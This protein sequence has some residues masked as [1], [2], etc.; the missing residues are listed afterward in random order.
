MSVAGSRPD[1]LSGIELLRFGAAFTVLI[2]HYF[3]FYMRGY[4]YEDYAFDRQPLFGV[5]EPL[6]RYGTRS[7]E[8]FWCLSG[9]I[10]FYQYGRILPTKAMSATRFFWLRFSRLYPL[11]FLT[12]LIV[13]LLQWVYH[14][15]HGVFFIVE[16]NNLKHFILNLLFVQY[17]GFQDG[18]SFNTPSWSVSVELL[19]YLFFYI[20]T[21]MFGAS[22]FMAILCLAACSAFSFLMGFEPVIGRCLFYFYAGGLACLAYEFIRGKSSVYQAIATLAGA[23]LIGVCTRRFEST[24]NVD[25]VLNFEIPVVLV[26]LALNSHFLTHRLSR[27]INALGNLTYGSYLLHFPI[28]ILIMLAV[29]MLGINHH[30]AASP[31]FLAAYI[32]GV[33]IVSHFAYCLFEMPA[34]RLIRARFAPP[35]Q[36]ESGQRT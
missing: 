8:V 12:L 19:I 13:A 2:A 26:V 23:I 18:F 5:L 22:F 9:F 34:Q 27:V 3:H 17:W 31:Y 14:V 36:S 1:R 29:D 33:L 21:R 4:A 32:V 11:H 25:F 10:F 15:T 20:A 35:L 6:Y 7:V 16:L 30:F 24:H 28:Q